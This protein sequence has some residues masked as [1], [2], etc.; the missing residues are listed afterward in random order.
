MSVDDIMRYYSPVYPHGGSWY[1]TINYMIKSDSEHLVIRELVRQARQNAGF[2]TPVILE[3]VELYKAEKEDSNARPDV[4]DGTH[5]VCV[6]NLLGLE[7]ILVQIRVGYEDCPEED[8]CVETVINV[9]G[10]SQ[11]DDADDIIFDALNSFPLDDDIWMTCSVISGHSGNYSVTWDINPEEVDE[12]LLDSITEK[13][14]L[15]LVQHGISIV[16]IKT[17]IETY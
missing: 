15:I 7:N 9:I 3:G 5:R 2:H 16:Q 6:A 8:V 13:V 1:D 10:E 17:S 11:N 4:I 12:L 14:S